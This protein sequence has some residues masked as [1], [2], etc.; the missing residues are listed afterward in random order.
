MSVSLHRPTKLAAVIA[1]ALF[2]THSLNHRAESS[3][4]GPLE[5]TRGVEYETQ[6]GA[7]SI[8]VSADPSGS[9]KL[10]GT[11]WAGNEYNVCLTELHP[12][13]ER[14]GDIQV[15]SIS[16][17]LVVPAETSLRAAPAFGDLAISSIG[18]E[19][20]AVTTLLKAMNRWIRMS[21]EAIATPSR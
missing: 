17:Q 4:A 15:V 20:R 19:L 12:P 9:A 18:D 16:S 5:V 11:A 6:T 10:R 1:L 2:I 3:F 21:P 14:N 13:V 8:A 7:R